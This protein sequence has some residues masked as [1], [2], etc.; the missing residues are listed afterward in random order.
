VYCRYQPYRIFAVDVTECFVVPAKSLL[1]DDEAG[2]EIVRHEQP[3]IE[4][5][6]IHRDWLLSGLATRLRPDDTP[7]VVKRRESVLTARARFGH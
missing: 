7:G 6:V 3:D 4:V 5:H 1:V 2:Q